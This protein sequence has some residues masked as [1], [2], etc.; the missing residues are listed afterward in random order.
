M[1]LLLFFFVFFT[2][3]LFGLMGAARLNRS[4]LVSLEKLRPGVGERD[5][6]SYG[7]PESVDSIID[8]MAAKSENEFYQLDMLRRL[9]VLSDLLAEV[10]GRVLILEQ[11]R[12][13]VAL[14][15]TGLSLFFGIASAFIAF[16]DLELFKSN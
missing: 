16:G 7:S 3:V 6:A 2:M 1:F 11:Q 5:V 13:V 8:A 4:D 12:M 14:L 15:V 10:T 9:N